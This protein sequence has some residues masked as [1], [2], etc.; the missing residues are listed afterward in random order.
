[1]SLIDAGNALSEYYSRAWVQVLIICVSLFICVFLSSIVYFICMACSIW[2]PNGKTWLFIIFH[3][4][5]NTTQHFCVSV[6]SLKFSQFHINIPEKDSNWP[7][8]GHM[9]TTG[10]VC[11]QEDGILWMIRPASHDNFYDGK[12]INEN[13]ELHGVKEEQYPQRSGKVL[14]EDG[15]QK[16]WEN[17]CNKHSLLVEI[18]PFLM[19]S[20]QFWDFLQF[21]EKIGNDML[22]ERMVK[23]K[24]IYHKVM[25]KNV[26]W[27][28]PLK[29]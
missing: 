6:A 16:Y 14:P 15:R 8:L 27:S 9:P 28:I 18:W 11:G 23:W 25:L 10:P 13:P 26:L 24:H 22:W 21:M 7:S 19:A 17:K 1:M 4:K 3:K 20:S 5:S 29:Y 2:D 12:N